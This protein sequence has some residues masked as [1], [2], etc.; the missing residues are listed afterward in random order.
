LRL[1]C[2]APSMMS[3]DFI[4]GIYYCN[5]AGKKKEERGRCKNIRVSDLLPQQ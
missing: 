4:S 3:S 2:R 1:F 5:T